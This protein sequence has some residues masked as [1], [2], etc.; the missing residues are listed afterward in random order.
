MITRALAI[1]ISI[2]SYCLRIFLAEPA[3]VTVALIGL[4]VAV[5]GLVLA[6]A[7]A[8]VKISGDRADDFFRSYFSKVAQAS[9]RPEVY[10]NDFYGRLS[11]L[12]KPFEL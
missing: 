3:K 9:Q 1:L 4:F 2:K 10:R 6:Y 7:V 5:A 8:P 12:R 11:S